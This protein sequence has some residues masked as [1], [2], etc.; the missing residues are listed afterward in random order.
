MSFWIAVHSFDIDHL[1]CAL[2]AKKT[3]QLKSLQYLYISYSAGQSPYHSYPGYWAA[4]NASCPRHLGTLFRPS[5]APTLW[6]HASGWSGD[7]RWSEQIREGSLKIKSP[8]RCQSPELVLQPR[9]ESTVD[10]AIRTFEAQQ[11]N[12]VSPNCFPLSLLFVTQLSFLNR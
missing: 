8:S 6:Y 5:L 11:V 12:S 9:G 1:Q 7:G 10:V 3:Q 2:V 4:D